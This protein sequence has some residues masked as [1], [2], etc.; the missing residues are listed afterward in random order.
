MDYYVIGS[1][2]MFHQ[3]LCHYNNNNNKTATKHS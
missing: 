3:I 1:D 2:I